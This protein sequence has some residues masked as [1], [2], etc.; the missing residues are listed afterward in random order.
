MV[1]MYK[2]TKEE[3]TALY[4]RV[5]GTDEG[6]TVLNNIMEICGIDRISADLSN[7]N[8]TYYNEGARALGLKIKTILNAK[9]I[10]NVRVK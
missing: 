6:K 2:L 4:N 7:P 8:I 1:Q 9:E 10:K 3:Q 5:F